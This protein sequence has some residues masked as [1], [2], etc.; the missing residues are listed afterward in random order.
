MIACAD[1][2]CWQDSIFGTSVISPCR[3]CQSFRVARCGFSPVSDPG[4][5]LLS[6][7]ERQPGRR[8]SYV[9]RLKVLGARAGSV[10][11]QFREPVF[12]DKTD[13]ALFEATGNTVEG[14]AM[15]RLAQIVNAA[16]EA[17]QEP[18]DA[19]LD[20]MLNLSVKARRKVNALSAQIYRAGWT[21]NGV[22][23]GFEEALPVSIGL[24]GAWR[25]RSATQ[26]SQ[27]TTRKISAVG[28]L[29]GWT[30]SKATMTLLTDDSKSLRVVVPPELQ[31]RVA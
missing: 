8:A 17:A 1:G 7:G 20:A 27:V 3:R 13:A 24:A 31:G 30:W 22:L 16:E 12:D 11:V 29:D 26:E 15:L 28:E 9:P 25:L 14:L 6:Y 5:K 4:D 21:I 2:V 23:L 19:Q 10:R 18:R